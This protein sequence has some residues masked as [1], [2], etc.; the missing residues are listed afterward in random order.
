ML[1]HLL[2]H[3]GRSDLRVVL[4]RDALETCSA[5]NDAS[6]KEACYA[7]FGCD[8]SRVEQYFGAVEVLETAWEQGDVLIPLQALRSLLYLL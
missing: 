5:L 8:G 7:T 2:L 1:S 6:S 4:H 3:R